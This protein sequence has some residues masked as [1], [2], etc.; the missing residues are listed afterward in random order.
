MITGSDYD[1]SME[2]HKIDVR[3]AAE[4]PFPYYMAST[5]E[6]GYW[7]TVVGHL[8]QVMALRRGARVLEIGFGY[9][10]ITE[11]LVR[12]GLHVDAIDV[13]PSF[14]ELLDLR[15]QPYNSSFRIFNM[16][17][18]D[19]YTDHKYDAVLFFESFHHMDA[20]FQA[21]L[22]AKS[23]LKG[24]EST[25]VFGAEPI[26]GDN[27]PVVPYPWGLRMDGR[28]LL[29]VRKNGWMEIGFRES[30]F[31]EMLGKAGFSFEKVW[32]SGYHHSVVFMAQS[33][34]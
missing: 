8:M 15:L 19:Y 17:F 4:K 7:L 33:V 22:K 34:S 18:D 24:K 13:S 30:Y 5:N 27:D 25:V 14:C 12:A 16:D 2:G 9:G 1:S 10:F 11:A 31:R 21:A 28:S 23:L 3:R 32:L 6:I 26:V 29:T 20:H